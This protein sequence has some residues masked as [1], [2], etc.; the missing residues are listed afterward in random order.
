MTDTD[1]AIVGGGLAGATAAAILG[2]AG[3]RTILIDPHSVYPP[4][5][6][7]EKLDS[8]QISILRK[9]GLADDI[10]PATAFDGD[11]HDGHVWIVRFGYMIDK[12]PGDQY[13]IL[14][15]DLVNTMRTAI[16]AGVPRLRAKA[17]G[18]SSGDDHQQVTLSDGT[19]IT[20]RLVVLAHGL[21][22]ALKDQV[23][24]ERTV[25]SSCHSITIAFNLKLRG[26]EAF[27]FGSLTYYPERTADRMAYLTLFPTR[28]MMRAN[29][30]VYRNMDDP[31]LREMRT[32]PE[33]TLFALM[34]NLHR[35]TG[36]IEIVGPIQIRPADLYVSK[37]HRQAGIVLVGDAFAT[38]CPAAG[39]GTKKVFTDVTR[40][41]NIHIPNWLASPGMAADKIAQY[42][43]D[44]V[45]CGVDNGSTSFAYQLRSV[46]IND[47]FIWGLRRTKHFIVRAAIGAARHLGRIARA[48]RV[49]S[50]GRARHLRNLGNRA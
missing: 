14:Y 35:F 39:T 50:E 31:W 13:G 3:I 47:G 20:A 49:A 37:G 26:T 15:D 6:R 1:V 18:L 43:D 42:Y 32:N 2:R 23:G 21:S 9:T 17:V 19:R 36:D 29:L 30:M 4:D 48:D 12:R 46:S 28:T 24:I 40:L 22:V 10:L 5:L 34:P 33:R 16:P 25:V 45:K 41:C 11:T 27:S 7:C 44:P 38:S 8:R